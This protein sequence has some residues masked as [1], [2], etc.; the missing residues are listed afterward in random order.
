MW[1][2][3]STFMAALAARYLTMA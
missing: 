1:R 2:S 3:R